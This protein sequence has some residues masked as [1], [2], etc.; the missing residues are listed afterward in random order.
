MVLEVYLL[1]RSTED[2]NIDVFI[3]QTAILCFSDWPST[4]MLPLSSYIPLLEKLSWQVNIKNNRIIRQNLFCL[5]IV[6]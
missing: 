3:I 2:I 6:I 4:S 5:V 1:Y